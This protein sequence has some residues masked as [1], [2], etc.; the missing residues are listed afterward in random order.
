MV[1]PTLISTVT[2]LET[3]QQTNLFLHLS[4]N[5]AVIIQKLKDELKG[6]SGGSMYVI[7]V[8]TPPYH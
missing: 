3:P 6:A 4:N 1:G 7:S 8:Y 5:E 2:T